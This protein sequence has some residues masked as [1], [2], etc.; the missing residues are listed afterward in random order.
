MVLPPPAPP[1]P[2]PPVPPVVPPAPVLEA[3]PINWQH[4]AIY[5]GV[6]LLETVCSAFDL[7]LLN[8]S[9]VFPPQWAWA[10]VIIQPVLIYV[11]TAL[12]KL[13]D[14]RAVAAAKRR[15]APR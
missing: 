7:A 3:D 5:G 6:G 8:H 1:D 12:P 13:T 11:T 10:T 14:S 2:L 15:A 9:I 4:V